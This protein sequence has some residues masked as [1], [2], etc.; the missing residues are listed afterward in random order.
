MN[1][2]IGALNASNADKAAKIARELAEDGQ[3]IRFALDMINESGNTPVRQPPQP[4]VEP[5]RYLL[6]FELI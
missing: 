6:R 2:L 5:F 4:V 3:S 1:E